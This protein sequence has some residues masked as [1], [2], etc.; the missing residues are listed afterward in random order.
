MKSMKNQEIRQI[1][2]IQAFYKEIMAYIKESSFYIL[3]CLLLPGETPEYP[4]IT[5]RLGRTSIRC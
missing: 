2:I 5:D 4:I 1:P 3:D